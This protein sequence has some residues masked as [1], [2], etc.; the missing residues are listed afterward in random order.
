MGSLWPALTDPVMREAMLDERWSPDAGERSLFLDN[1]ASL[2]YLIGD[3]AK[4]RA[5]ADS[6]AVLLRQRLKDR[7]ED[8]QYYIALSRVEALRG[9]REEARNAIERAVELR[10]LS[11]DA[12]A[13]PEVLAARAVTLTLTGDYEEAAKQFEELLA[14]PSYV[15]RNGLRLNPLFAPLRD[16]P[17]FQRL[18]SQAR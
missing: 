5:Y 6:A 16:N 18:V 4:A 2:Y 13:G 3:A 17:R 1:K 7:A 11:R 10:P 9:N 8:A 12:Y 15:S 14:I